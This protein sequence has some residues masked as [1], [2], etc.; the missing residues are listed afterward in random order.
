MTN[1]IIII[2]PHCLA[3]GLGWQLGL[4]RCGPS[5]ITLP[6]LC[7]SLGAG[8]NG[9]VL[10]FQPMLYCCLLFRSACLLSSFFATIHS[11]WCDNASGTHTEWLPS[12]QLRLSVPSVQ[13]HT[14]WMPGVYQVPWTT[15]TVWW[16]CWVFTQFECLIIP[17]VQWLLTYF[18]LLLITWCGGWSFHFLLARLLVMPHSSTRFFFLH[19]I[20]LLRFCVLL[21]LSFVV[22]SLL[23]TR[24]YERNSILGIYHESNLT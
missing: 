7:C 17:A 24:C 10:L 11:S 16:Y 3:A 12:V 21:L 23:K 19:Q 5:V 15:A 9:L 4:A 20:C 2:A 18:K 22:L 8:V 13:P 14:E 6:Y 1:L